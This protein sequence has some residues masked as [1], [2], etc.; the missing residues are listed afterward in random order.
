MQAVVRVCAC[1]IY[2]DSLSPSSG[3]GW[4]VPLLYQLS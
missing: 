4:Y 1:P 3:T 2:N